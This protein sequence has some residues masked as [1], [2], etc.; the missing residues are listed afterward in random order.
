MASFLVGMQEPQLFVVSEVFSEHFPQMFH[1]LVKFT[2]VN[3]E[4][5]VADDLHNL[6]GRV[7]RAKLG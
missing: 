2:P 3:A 1:A 7:R 6:E 4:K 5:L